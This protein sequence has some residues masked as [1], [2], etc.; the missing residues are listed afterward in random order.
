MMFVESAL[1][2]RLPPDADESGDQVPALW[3]VAIEEYLKDTENQRGRLEDVGSLRGIESVEQLAER[4]QAANQSF[5]D[6]RSRH[7]RLW[8]T[9]KQF[10]NPLVAA[11]RVTGAAAGADTLGLPAA[12]VL[13]AAVFLIEE[14]FSESRL[15]RQVA[16]LGYQGCEKVSNAFDWIDQVLTELMEFS[17][18]LDVYSRSSMDAVLKKKS[19]GI[20]SL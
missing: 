2:E 12:V 14:C 9:L 18:R 10:A 8:G 6:F 1:A 3:Q 19:I 5:K 13:N 16:D 7:S 11:M 4:L 17:E 15:I 20:L